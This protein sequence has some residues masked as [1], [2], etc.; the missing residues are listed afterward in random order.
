MEMFY[1]QVK[2]SDEFRGESFAQTFPEFYDL[3]KLYGNAPED[4]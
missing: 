2:F 1:K 4:F 3:L